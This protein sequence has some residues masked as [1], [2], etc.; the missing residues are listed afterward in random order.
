MNTT[1][2]KTIKECLDDLNKKITLR[3]GADSTDDN[4]LVELLSAL[5]VTKDTLSY[6]LRGARY[7]VGLTFFR[8]AFVLEKCGYKIKKISTMHESIKTVAKCLAYGIITQDDLDG[9]AKRTTIMRLISGDREL[10]EEYA[11][12]FQLICEENIANLLAFEESL[13][14]I[15]KYAELNQL[16]NVDT[17]SHPIIVPAL[18]TDECAITVAKQQM[19]EAL[20]SMTQAMRPLADYLLSDSCTAADREKF[21]M[22]TQRVGVFDLKNKLARLCGE[23]A[24][25]T[26]QHNGGDK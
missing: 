21:R 3:F 18:D 13:S 2:E 8:L 5:N 20:A 10:G 24:R 7:P 23:R 12:Y 1:D 17:A 6:W 16:E 11:E 14:K 4:G 15:P 22:L 9:I 19:I 25:E 26:L